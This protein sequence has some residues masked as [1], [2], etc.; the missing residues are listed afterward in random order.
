MIC[1]RIIICVW[2][3]CLITLTAGDASLSLR[4]RGRNS[5]LAPNTMP[6]HNMHSIEYRKLED[7]GNESSE[8]DDYY[9]ESSE[10]DDYYNDDGQAVGDDEG[11]WQAKSYDD[12]RVHHYEQSALRT[13][14]NM[15]LIP[16][17]EWSPLQWFFFSLMLILFG[18]CFFCCCILCVVPRCCGQKGTLMYSAMLV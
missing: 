6:M 9:T 8:E 17:H 3:L 2:L 12:D 11:S 7:S 5:A 18:S 14:G 15:F 16:P 13:T 1:I 10:E 4:L